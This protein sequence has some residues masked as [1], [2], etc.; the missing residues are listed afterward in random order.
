MK[1]QVLVFLHT[2]FERFDVLRPVK[3]SVVLKIVTCNIRRVSE[4]ED[5]LLIVSKRCI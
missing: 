1:K 5:T 4:L 3:I 2:I